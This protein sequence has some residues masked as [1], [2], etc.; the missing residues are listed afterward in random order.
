MPTSSPCGRCS[1]PV[2]SE[3]WKPPAAADMSCVAHVFAAGLILQCGLAFAQAPARPQA[4]SYARAAQLPARIRK[5]TATPETV[6][7]GQSATLTWAIEKPTSVTIDPGVG[8]V[9][10]RGAK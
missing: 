7:P 3:C 6:K 1:A 10:P 5:F 4:P 9:R 8:R 2:R